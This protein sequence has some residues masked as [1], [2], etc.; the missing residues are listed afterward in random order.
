MCILTLCASF[1]YLFFKK[2]VYFGSSL[3]PSVTYSDCLQLLLLLLLLLLLSSHPCASVSSLL[4][5][6]RQTYAYPKGSS[7]VVVR[8]CRWMLFFFVCVLLLVSFGRVIMKRC[9]W[10]KGI[11]KK[12]EKKTI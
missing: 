2:N 5:S 10:G 1:I 12:E 9:V 8:I 11:L 6:F 4:L 7:R 3:G